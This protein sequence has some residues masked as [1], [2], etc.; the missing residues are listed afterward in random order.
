MEQMLVKCVLHPYRYEYT[1]S[2]DQL[3]VHHCT[4]NKGYNPVTHGSSLLFI[5]VIHDNV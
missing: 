4:N 3:T 5:K 1:T 2:I